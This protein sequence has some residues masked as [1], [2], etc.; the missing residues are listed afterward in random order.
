MQD[1]LNPGQGFDGPGWGDIRPFS[2]IDTEEIRSTITALPDPLDPVLNTYLRDFDEV[3]D[4]GILEDSTRTPQETQTGL[5]YA[6]DGANNIGVPMRLFNQMV[7]S[8]VFTRFPTVRD[9]ARFGEL[10]AVELF[11]KVNIA[12]GDCGIQAWHEKYR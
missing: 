11:A 6:Y 5:F 1:P 10:N 9:Q 2:F 7:R 8:I 4:L 3:L 12:M